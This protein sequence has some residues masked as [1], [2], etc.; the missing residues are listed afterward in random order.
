[1][2]LGDIFDIVWG[3][4]LLVILACVAITSFNNGNYIFTIGALYGCY[5]VLYK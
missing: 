3:F 1:M 4:V 5:W 2:Y